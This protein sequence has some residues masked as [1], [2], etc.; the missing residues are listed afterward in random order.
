MA[1]SSIP[2]TGPL[3]I[4][5]F[6]PT[7]VFRFRVSWLRLEA[8]PLSIAAE[9]RLRACAG[10][11]TLVLLLLGRGWTGRRAGVAFAV[12]ATLGVVTFYNF[13]LFRHFND[14][15]FINH[16]EHF[17][18]QL[19]AK[20]FPE[21]GYDGLYVAS[22]AAQ[23]Q[24][25]P[26]S[27]RQTVIRDLRSNALTQ[28][29]ELAGHIAEVRERFSPDRWQDFVA[30]HRYYLRVNDPGVIDGIRRDHGY[31]PTPTWTFVARLFGSHLPASR[32]AL[33]LLSSLDVLLLVAAFGAIARV[34]PVRI[35]AIALVVFGVGYGWRYIYVGAFLRLDWL[36]AIALGLCALRRGRWVVA[37]VLFGYAT[38]VRVFPVLLLFGPGVLAVGAWLRGER[39]RWP[40]QL[41]AGFAAALVVGL[42]VGSVTGRGFAA[43]PEF[44]ENIQLHRT[45]WAPNSVG[46][47]NIV[48]H[49]ARLVRQGAVVPRSW[50]LPPGEADALL[51]DRQLYA[52]LGSGLLL[53]LLAGA[54]WGAPLDR[55]AALGIAGIFALTPLS[56]YYWIL[57]IALPLAGAEGVALGFVAVCAGLYALGA[58]GAP[59]AWLYSLLSIALGALLVG[60]MAAEIRSGRI[61]ARSVAEGRD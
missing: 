37:G 11:A 43:W 25:D 13:G 50:T 35:F 55:A 15:R 3:S 41:G 28:T 45:S 56:S 21:L 1:L 17:H 10:L 61:D 44:A 20:Y 29:S 53:L 49:G 59:S 4:R 54:A 39:P 33:A 9:D 14:L 46:L 8:G 18:Y 19:G 6:H 2:P 26:D 16:W 60:W 34:H 38:L 40:L 51:R 27:P 47:E 42:G 23:R 48:V 24:V 32:W 57:L 12:A 7:E 31:N 30:D 58:I 5:A 22:L 52:G 36:A